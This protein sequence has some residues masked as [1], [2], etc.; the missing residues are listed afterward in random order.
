[1]R[2]GSAQA[3]A[4]GWEVP[5]VRVDNIA[6]GMDNPQQKIGDAFK[7]ARYWFKYN[8]FVRT[9]TLLRMGFY[10]Y[11]FTV[12]AHAASG[13]TKALEKWWGTDEQPN[14]ENQSKA[15]KYVRSAWTDWLLMDN[16]VAIWRKDPAVY[17]VPLAYPPEEAEYKDSFG[18]ERLELQNIIDSKEQKE[19]LPLTGLAPEE[20]R[21][22]TIKLTKENKTPWD[23]RY[24]FDV[25]KRERIG[26]GFG[27]P[28]MAVLYQTCSQQEGIEVGDA[29]LGNL[30]RNVIEQHQVGH[31]IKSGTHAGSPAHFL[32]PLKAKAIEKNLKGKIGHIRLATNFDHKIVYVVPPADGFEARRYDGVFRRLEAWAMPLAQMIFSKGGLN[33]Y[34]LQI[35]QHQAGKER[36]IM[37]PHL[38]VVLRAALGMPKDVRVQWSDQC[39]QDNKIAADMIKYGLASGP[40]SQQT[41]LERNGFSHQTERE[42]K[43]EEAKLGEE[44]TH[45]IYDAH[46]GPPKAPAGRKRGTADGQ[47]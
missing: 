47:G 14:E 44:Q 23:K 4:S 46:H 45:P 11:G 41:W 10:D 9:M 3:L 20:L 17:G 27:W 12:T 2:A 8:L 18:V 16:V 5:S 29:I 6:C 19:L 36:E 25:V 26:V 37:A 1:M 43:A 38:N 34:L 22:P 21:S 13:A 31:D 35:F 33:P 24:G 30:C 40:V 42:R 15:R 32:K 39:F 28:G 7:K